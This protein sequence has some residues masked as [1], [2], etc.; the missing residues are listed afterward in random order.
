MGALSL[1]ATAS[2]LRSVASRSSCRLRRRLVA[3]SGF[4]HTIS[5]SAGY[6]S[7][8]LS[9]AMSRSSKIDSCRWPC[10]TSVRIAG[11]RRAVI[12]DRPPGSRSSRMRALVS[13]PRS[14]TMIMRS[15]EKRS[16]SFC[17][18][19]LNV[20]GSAVLP[21]KTSTATGHPSRLQSSAKT[22]WGLP[23]LP[24]LE[25]PRRARAHFAP[26]K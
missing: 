1:R 23:G 19:A 14:P 4:R 15:S 13:R 12:H 26:S 17:T 22:I 5:R 24:S 9:S 6:S 20:P 21:S 7:G 3:S 25:Y 8:A 10:C 18:W 2:S 11:A 16:L